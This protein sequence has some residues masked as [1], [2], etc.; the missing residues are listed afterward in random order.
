MI[1]RLLEL[2]IDGAVIVLLYTV[3]AFLLGDKPAAQ[4]VKQ[5]PYKWCKVNKTMDMVVRCKRL[6]RTP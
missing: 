3:L 6:T 1:E 4:E 5:A 2:A